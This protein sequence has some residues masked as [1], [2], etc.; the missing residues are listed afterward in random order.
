MLTRL[1]NSMFRREA[2]KG[3]RTFMLSW[4]KGGTSSEAKRNKM[5]EVKPHIPHMPKKSVRVLKK[6]LSITGQQTT[7]HQ[8]LPRI[9]SPV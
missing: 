9:L 5:I 7:L 8:P 3:M 1:N 2:Q 4:N 6:E